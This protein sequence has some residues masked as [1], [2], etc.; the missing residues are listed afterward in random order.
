MNSDLK[1]KDK[2]FEIVKIIKNPADF[3]ELMEL[4]RSGNDK[5]KGS[6]AE[7]MK[8]VSQE[9]P[10]LF[11][12]YIDELINHINSKVNRVKWGIPEAIHY[13]A[14]KHPE[15]V[16]NAVPKLLE[17]T[18]DKS[19]VV[20]WCAAFALSSI[21]KHNK[22]LQKELI[23]TFEQLIKTENNNGIRNVY[24]NSLKEIKQ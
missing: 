3:K 6:C 23:K 4:F 9:K 12:P 16:S 24:L 7:V 14:E 17:N 2:V 18:K 11:L 22:K 15:K 19:I 20:R 13:I 5:L 21:A 1:H 8:F 10:E